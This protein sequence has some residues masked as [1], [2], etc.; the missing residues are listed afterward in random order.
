MSDAEFP[1]FDELAD[2]ARSITPE[3]R[4]RHTP[5]AELWANIEASSRQ[6]DTELV[7]QPDAEPLRHRSPTRGGLAPKLLVAAAAAIVFIIGLTLL[8]SSGRA[9]FD[10]FVGEVTN[11]EQPEAFDG[12][13]TAI[14]EV[15]DTP[16]L[17]IEFSEGL[18]D[19]A[20]VEIWL[21]DGGDGMLIS[22]GIVPAGATEWSGD[23]PSGADPETYNVVWL[24]L[25]SDNDPTPSGRT[26]LRGELRLR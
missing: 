8:D 3:D 10:T 1:E 2:I 14:V 5:P 24:S 21:G 23:W 6:H 25:E 11:A 20:P 13:A 15:D 19:E 17:D 18:P 7:D 22:L 26:F 12:T 9:D 16:T 4:V